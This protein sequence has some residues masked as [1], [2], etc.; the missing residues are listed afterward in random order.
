MAI[1]YID[2]TTL[3]NSNG[4]YMD[5]ALTTFAA[6]SYYSDGV[7]VRQQVCTGNTCVLNPPQP[8][9]TCYEPCGGSLNASGAGGVFRLNISLGGTPTDVG[10]V[11]IKFDPQGVPDGIEVQYNG[12][13]YNKVSSPQFG[14]LQAQNGGGQPVSG[15]T[16]LGS[17]GSTGQ[18][19]GGL[20]N[21]I[22]GTYQLNESEYLG[23]T[24]V[25]TGTTITETITSDN[26][27]LTAGQPGDCVMVI[28]KTTGQ[29]ELLEVSV[30]APCGGTQWDIEVACP[31]MI[32]PMLGVMKTSQTG[33][34]KGQ[35]SDTELYYHVPVNGQSTQNNVN[36]H[37]YLF[38]DG[39]GQT[40][41]FDN[42][43]LCPGGFVV[44]TTNGIVD[45][46][47]DTCNTITLE[48]C[49]TGQFY[50]MN[51]RFNGANAVGD[52]IQYKRVNFTNNTVD[53]LI[54]CGTITALGTG[55]DVNAMQEGAISYSCGDTT[56]C[57]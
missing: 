54:Y 22:E 43:Y 42:Y 11:I 26:D 4:I 45:Q 17:T 8:C 39:F 25:P 53:P 40:A 7:V 55:T 52:V 50:T 21:Q 29:P 56:H 20:P 44:H 37:D 38:T 49:T 47:F 10:A 19:G 12:T 31:T 16:Y 36:L 6:A 28:P 34:C 1:F 24:F 14:W 2:G 5:A 18:C 30:Y 33:A 15:R 46:K 13:A 48:D 41:V 3:S 35:F 23:G 9:P 27:Q 32:P 57:P 51:D